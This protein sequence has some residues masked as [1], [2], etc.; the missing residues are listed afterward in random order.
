MET[1]S[2]G[3]TVKERAALGY[4]GRLDT[5]EEGGRPTRDMEQRRRAREDAV[6][7]WAVGLAALVRGSPPAGPCGR[8][9][10]WRGLWVRKTSTQQPT[11]RSESRRA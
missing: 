8:R 3:R 5:T 11:H 6:Q 1:S 4:G 10:L 7:G 2:V 9:P